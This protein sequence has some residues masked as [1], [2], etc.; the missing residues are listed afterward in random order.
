[1][2]P[3]RLEGRESA[4]ET[5]YVYDRRG[6]LVRSVTRREPSFTEQDRAELLALALYREQLCPMH[7]GPRSECEAKEGETPP[8]FWASSSYCHV[9]VELI[10][11]QSAGA[12]DDRARQYAPAKLWKVRPRR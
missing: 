7:G 10:E 11:A 1:M 12:K 8:S 2:A 6:R 3:S 4:T 9:Q 5:R